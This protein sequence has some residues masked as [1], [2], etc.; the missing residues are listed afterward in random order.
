M[1]AQTLGCAPHLKFNCVAYMPATRY[2]MRMGELGDPW[3]LII[4]IF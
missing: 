1:L 3:T 2:T 4:S